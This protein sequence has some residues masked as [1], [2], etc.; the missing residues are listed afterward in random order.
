S[1][2]TSVT[3]IAD[4]DFESAPGWTVQ[5]IALTD[6][7]WERGVPVFFDRGSPEFDFDGSGSC[8]LTDN[9]ATSSNSD[10]DGGP[11]RLISPVYDL[12]GLTAATISYARWFYND[13]PDIDRLTVEVSS[14][15][16]ASWE[17]VEVVG[18][19]GVWV[20][21]AWDVGAFVPLTDQ[22]RI[23][24]SAIDNPNISVTEA[25]IDAFKLLSAECN[26][27]RADLTGDGVL[28]FFDFLEFQD[29]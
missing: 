14:N 22:F 10:V 25:A 9:D 15:G 6:G 18:H 12:S 27:C 2:V 13:A 3:T 20:Q 29:L 17:V 24:F 28:D 16:G 7:A 26:T 21:K 4:L 11:T 5:N 23:R 19:S 8:F 1:V